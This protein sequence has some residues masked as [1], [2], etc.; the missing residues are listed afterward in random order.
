M[1]T[2]EWNMQSSGMATYTGIDQGIM[3]D[4]CADLIA[5]DDAN[6]FVC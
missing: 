6:N 2:R 1:V 4:N 5:D 3:P